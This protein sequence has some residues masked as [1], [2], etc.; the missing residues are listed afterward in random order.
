M[1]ATPSPRWPFAA[2][3][4]IA[5]LPY[6]ARQTALDITD[7]VPERRP[8]RCHAREQAVM[9]GPATP[10]PPEPLN[11]IKLRTITQ[12]PIY[13]QMGMGRE[14]VLHSRPQCQGALSIVRTTSG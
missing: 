7:I 11:D 14:P 12:Q 6:T 13:V 8:Q 4:P 1:P 2:G 10:H 5:A 3:V 9:C